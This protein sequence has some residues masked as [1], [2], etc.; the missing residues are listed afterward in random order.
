MEN[1]GVVVLPALTGGRGY[2]SGDASNGLFLVPVLAR[3][4]LIRVC[5]LVTSTYQSISR[6][7][8]LVH[9]Y[10]HVDVTYHAG[11]NCGKSL[12]GIHVCKIRRAADVIQW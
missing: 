3:A 12:K 1:T 10:L 4:S 2:G 11:S 7:T 6:V 5:T 8:K 9:V